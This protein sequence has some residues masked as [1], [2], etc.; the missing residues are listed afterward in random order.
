MVQIVEFQGEEIEFPDDMADADIEAVLARESSAQP[1]ER[2]AQPVAQSTADPIRGRSGRDRRIRKERERSENL[3]SEFEAGN[4]TS[5]DLTDSEVEQVR[6]ARIAKIPEISKTGLKGLSDNLG[7]MQAVAALTTFNPAEFARIAIEADP[8]LSVLTTPEGETLLSN[9]R[10]NEIVSVN[11]IGPSFM[12][13]LQIGAVGAAFSPGTGLAAGLGGT[14]L[15]RAGTQ[16]LAA[17]VTESAL[18]G[19]QASL[20]GEF[21]LS[22]V[23]LAGTFAGGAEFVAPLFRATRDAFKALRRSRQTAAPVTKEVA[24]EQFRSI[25]AQQ[26]GLQNKLKS[27]GINPK[28][29]EETAIKALS[30]APAN[31][32][33]EEVI[34]SALFKELDIPTLKSRITQEGGQFQIEQELRAR[35]DVL[36]QQVRERVAEEAVGFQQALKNIIDDTGLPEEAGETIKGVL[37]SRKQDLRVAERKAYKRLSKLQGEGLPVFTS[38]IE[39]TFENA[40]IIK[41]FQRRNPA[42]FKNL[43]D[44]LVE[45]GVVK[46]DDAIAGFSDASQIKSLGVDTIEDF[47]QSLNEFVDPSDPLKTGV[48]KLLIKRLDEEV[49]VLDKSLDAVDLGTAGAKAKRK[50]AAQ[51]TARRISAGSKREF[52]EKN[53]VG[54]LTSSKRGTFDVPLVE[55]DNVVRSLVSKSKTKPTFSELDRVMS[56]LEKSGKK[57]TQAIG[58][59]QASTIMNLLEESTKGLSSKPAAGVVGFSGANYRKALNGIGEKELNRLFKDSPQILTTLKKL[60]VAAELTQPISDVMNSSQSGIILKNFINDKLRIIPGLAEAAKGAGDVAQRKQ[61]QK[62]ARSALQ[63]KFRSTRKAS[64]SRFPKITDIILDS[65]GSIPGTQEAAQ[66][67]RAR[68][69]QRSQEKQATQQGL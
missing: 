20:G 36:G 47:R 21:D 51:R 48:S 2:Q 6:K 29:L 5:A 59:L 24:I 30:E 69:E 66:I 25:Y 40:G 13:A 45:F 31:A 42:E 65:G 26:E 64:L 9:R 28:Q 1:V 63:A 54:R 18:Q 50:I 55:A 14:A 53:I 11:K 7:F 33:P 3:L 46:S 19:T 58:N 52:N 57:G 56:S 10:T 44:T 16:A 62:S 17:G 23:A 68:K 61:A 22:D 49:K 34:A 32:N 43:Q 39:K 12:D 4:I 27:L 35:P 15:K 8:D 41:R 37:S 60:S 67:L 38:R